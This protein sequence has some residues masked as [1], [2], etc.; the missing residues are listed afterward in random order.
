MFSLKEEIS[1][2][3]FKIMAC[4]KLAGQYLSQIHADF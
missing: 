4:K 3:Q 2:E 1:E